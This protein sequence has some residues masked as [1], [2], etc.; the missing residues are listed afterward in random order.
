MLANFSANLLDFALLIR[1][2]RPFIK[3]PVVTPARYYVKVQMPNYLAGSFPVITQH[4][5]S[6]RADGIA[7]G[8]ADFAKG[9][10]NFG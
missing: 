6:I 3:N 7:N 10:D 2:R 8:L 1:K 9:H 4:V 5:V